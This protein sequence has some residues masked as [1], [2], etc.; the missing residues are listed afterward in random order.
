MKCSQNQTHI[1]R[2]NIFIFYTIFGVNDLSPP[3]NKSLISHN[4]ES[5]EYGD[6]FE[7]T[8]TEKKKKKAWH[9]TGQQAKTKPFVLIRIVICQQSGKS[10]S[11]SS[12]GAKLT[13]KAGRIT[14]QEKSVPHSNNGQVTFSH[15]RTPHSPREQSTKN[16]GGRNS[17]LPKKGGK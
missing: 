6:D 16:G 12:F 15:A 4:G 10:F 3:T 1:V 7:V 14:K 2:S 8:K 5:W 9:R 17:L 13:A 11:F